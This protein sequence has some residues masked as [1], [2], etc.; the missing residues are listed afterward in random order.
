MDWIYWVWYRV[1]QGAV[2]NKVLDLV[3]MLSV[4]TA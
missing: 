3:V 4:W 1:W 2:G